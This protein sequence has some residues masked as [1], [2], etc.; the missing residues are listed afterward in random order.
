MISRLLIVSAC[1]LAASHAT[2]SS[3]T[4]PQLP[5]SPLAGLPRNIGQWQQDTSAPVDLPPSTVE[6]LGVDEYLNRIYQSGPESLGLFVGYYASQRQGD[7]IHSPLNC[8]PGAGWQPISRTYLEVPLSDGRV[9]KV[10]RYVIEKGLDREV[11]LYWYESHGRIVPNEYM[12]KFYL[13][14]DAIRLNRTDAALV[15]VVS[16]MAA[17]TADAESQATVRGVDFVRALLPALAP[18]LPS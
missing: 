1:L 15:R 17:S 8:L 5:R 13:V 11:V 9:V 14:Y 6:G 3:K 4:E 10:N 7:T 12:S 16:P 18:H 2:G